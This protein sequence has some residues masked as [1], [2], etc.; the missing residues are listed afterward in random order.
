MNDSQ[1]ALDNM[2]PTYS[3]PGAPEKSSKTKIQCVGCKFSIVEIGAMAFS[4]K[5]LPIP[6]P[7][8][9]GR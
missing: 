2:S 4:S 9:V 7:Q 8:E 5:V 3:V 1:L 6:N